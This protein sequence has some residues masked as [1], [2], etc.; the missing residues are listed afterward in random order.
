MTKDEAL[1]L[2]AQKDCATVIGKEFMHQEPRTCRDVWPGQVS[3]WCA[4]CIAK[5]AVES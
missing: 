5:E 1:R 2:I 4:A 3:E